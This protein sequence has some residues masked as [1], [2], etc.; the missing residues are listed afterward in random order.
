MRGRRIGACQ[1]AEGGGDVVGTA[2]LEGTGGEGSDAEAG[3]ARVVG[4]MVDLGG[5]ERAVGAVA[6][7][8]RER[9]LRAREG[10]GDAAVRAPVPVGQA[11]SGVAGDRAQLAFGDGEEGAVPGE[12]PPAAVNLRAAGRGS[13][14]PGVRQGVGVPAGRVEGIAQ[15]AALHFADGKLQAGKAVQGEEGHVLSKC[16]GWNAGR[17]DGQGGQE[18]ATAR[19]GTGQCRRR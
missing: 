2:G 14:D 15:G 18:V 7:G 11:E 4:E 19:A 13:A 6:S 16:G 9:A 8:V 1:A 10:G 5:A 17:E 3:E 12:E